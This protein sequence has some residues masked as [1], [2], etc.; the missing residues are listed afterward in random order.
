MP[1]SAVDDPSNHAAARGLPPWWAIVGGAVAI[2][3]VL[4]FVLS[5]AAS[6]ERTRRTTVAP[7]QP[8][9]TVDASGPVAPTATGGAQP[10]PTRI[11]GHLGET[12]P[13]AGTNADGLVR[14]LT[15][16]WGV[17]VRTSTYPGG[18]GTRSEGG[19]Y[20]KNHAKGFDLALNADAAG[21]IHGITCSAWSNLDGPLAQTYR[22]FLHDCVTGAAGDKA[23][24]IGAW[25]DRAL[26]GK[27]ITISTAKTPDQRVNRA[28]AGLNLQVAY[29]GLAV[30][31][32]LSAPLD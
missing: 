15:G 14:T 22:D 6:P 18:I 2:V 17:T 28:V 5:T 25:L 8:A 11:P 1:E 10:K 20:D 12:G 27:V 13:I 16:K 19:K 26:V 32:S 21:R 4:A 7:S 24:D 30:L 29:G 3:A 31:V 23:K 9:H